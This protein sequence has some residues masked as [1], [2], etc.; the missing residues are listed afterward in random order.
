MCAMQ[1]Y[2]LFE[3]FLSIV[4][5]IDCYNNCLENALSFRVNSI[6]FPC[7]STGIF[8]FPNRNAAQIA[9]HTVRTWLEVN[10]SHIEQIIF[11]TYEDE[12]FQIYK[13]LMPE[14]FPISDES[15][16]VDKLIKENDLAVDIVDEIVVVTQ[17]TDSEYKDLPSSSTSILTLP[18]ERKSISEVSNGLIIAERT[19]MFV[20]DINA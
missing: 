8:K 9:I 17:D 15:T 12:D 14:Y 4:T 11:C 3:T 7:I 18:T 6:A 13:E 10:S 20:D 5:T 1:L 19:N 2:P 16:L